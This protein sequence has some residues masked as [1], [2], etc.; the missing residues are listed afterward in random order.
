M[1]SQMRD[2]RIFLNERSVTLVALENF[3]ASVDLHVTFPVVA[4]LKI[5]ITY[6]ALE[7]SLT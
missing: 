5:S 4:I 1:N 3:L 2:Q 7:R 6:L